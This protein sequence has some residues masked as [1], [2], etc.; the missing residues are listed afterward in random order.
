MALSS[1]VNR[2]KY[3]L[4]SCCSSPNQCP[5]TFLQRSDFP[6]EFIFGVATSAY[7]IEGAVSKDGRSMSIWDS[8]SHS[9]EQGLLKAKQRK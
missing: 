4:C 5:S 1:P 2:A 3:P 7:Q 6:P 8:F 9:P